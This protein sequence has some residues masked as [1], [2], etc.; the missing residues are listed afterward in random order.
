MIPFVLMVALAAGATPTRYPDG[1]LRCTAADAIGAQDDGSLSKGKRDD[2]WLRHYASFTA[3]LH[4]GTVRLADGDKPE[5]WIARPQRDH[6]HANG[7]SARCPH[8]VHRFN[9]DAWE[10]HRGWRE[11]GAGRL[12]QAKAFGVRG[13]M[14]DGGPAS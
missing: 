9:R 12:L 5:D 10:A 3:D 1:L 8:D 2:I 7:T 13:G 6:P 4:T 11:G 14:S